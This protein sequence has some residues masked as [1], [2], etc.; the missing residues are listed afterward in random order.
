MPNTELTPSQ[1]EA[2][3]GLLE[4]ERERLNAHFEDGAADSGL[5]GANE[6]ESVGEL[7][8]YDNHPGDL[9][10]ETFERERDMAI[11]DNFRQK[12]AEIE[13]ALDRLESEEYGLC[14]LCGKP[15]RYERLEALPATTRCV[16]HASAGPEDGSGTDARASVSQLNADEERTR[17]AARFD[18]AGAWERLE[19]Y[20]NASDTV[21]TGNTRK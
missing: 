13:A 10:T 8:A 9:G 5:R 14:D 6:T 12:L 20:G 1:L 21:T 7:S 4:E 16:T 15:I 19:A 18:D 17:Q 2:L 3:R 11:D